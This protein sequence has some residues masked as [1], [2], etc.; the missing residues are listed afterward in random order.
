ME[1]GAES[2]TLRLFDEFGDNTLLVEAQKQLE[3]KGG[4]MPA[5]RSIGGLDKPVLQSKRQGGT[6]L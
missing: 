5:A 2:Q 1:T 6:A 4:E 3:A